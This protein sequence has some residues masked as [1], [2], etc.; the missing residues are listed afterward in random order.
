M[1]TYS[2][3]VTNISLTVLLLTFIGECLFLLYLSYCG[4]EGL[5]DVLVIILGASEYE[6]YKLIIRPLVK[7]SFMQRSRSRS[8]ALPA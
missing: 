5:A 8:R 4:Y 1:K 6:K 3:Q 7:K 2:R